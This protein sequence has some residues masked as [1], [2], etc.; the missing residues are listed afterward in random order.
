MGR[1]EDEP[2]LP[3]LLIRVFEGHDKDGREIQ[4]QVIFSDL[5]HA[6]DNLHPALRLHSGPGDLQGAQV[7]R[8]Y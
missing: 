8:V 4:R 1:G 5:G 2:P 3:D 7:L 6:C